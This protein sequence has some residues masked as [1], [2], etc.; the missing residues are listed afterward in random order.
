[1]KSDL[2]K[3]TQYADQLFETA[4]QRL[5]DTITFESERDCMKWNL[6]EILK[7]ELESE[8][9]LL[10]YNDADKFELIEFGGG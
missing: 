5:I 3:E 2:I 8:G 4:T 10:R 6:R 7:S 1:M 9:Y